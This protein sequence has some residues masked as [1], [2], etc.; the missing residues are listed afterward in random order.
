MPDRQLVR[1]AAVVRQPPQPPHGGELADLDPAEHARLL[2]V[3]SDRTDQRP[4]NA[5]TARA[6][7]DDCQDFARWCVTRGLPVLPT[8]DLALV[9]YLNDCAERGDKLSTIRRRLG[10]IAK[11]HQL[12]G[13]GNPRS[14]APVRQAWTDLRRERGHTDQGS[15][16]RAAPAR[17]PTLRTL[18]TAAG[19]QD[20][21]LVGCRDRALLLIGWACALR[22]SEYGALA[23][24]DMI[25][26]DDGLRVHLRR[27]KTDQYGEGAILEVPYGQH[28]ETCPVR[29][30]QS[31]KRRGG[32]TS[33]P[34]FPAIDQWG[35][36]STRGIS[37]SGV[38]FVLRRVTIAAGLDPANLTG[39]SLRSGF[40]SEAVRAGVPDQDV[41]RQ[42]RHRSRAV[43]DGYVRT[44][45][46][47]TDSAAGKVGL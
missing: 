22:R 26:D 10:G 42:S 29:A 23:V 39:H 41:M 15:T 8:T 12:A 25:D 21:P 19:R 35:H 40:I 2:A 37:G 38:M 1:P 18:V 33:G 46:P 47:M 30:W 24:E 43:F 9:G 36:L 14:T 4:K 17:L 16:R 11:A 45:R 6:Y 7:R 13:Y 32:L 20:D 3:F 27:S 28:K 5:N 44:S 31:W 34:A